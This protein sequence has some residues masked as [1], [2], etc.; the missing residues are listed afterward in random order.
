MPRA[1][2]TAIFACEQAPTTLGGVGLESA[3]VGVALA[4]NSHI[5]GVWEMVP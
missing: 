2:V 4:A 5:P 1:Q 3:I